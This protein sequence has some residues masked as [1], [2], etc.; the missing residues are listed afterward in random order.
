MPSEE[1]YK[2]IPC[3][4]QVKGLPLLQG[5]GRGEVIWALE[6]CV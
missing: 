2:M 1:S 6:E 3:I 5:E 4:I